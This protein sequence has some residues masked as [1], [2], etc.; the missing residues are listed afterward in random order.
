MLTAGKDGTDWIVRIWN[1]ASGTELV[2]L[3]GHSSFVSRAT[4]SQDE[5]RGVLT[6]SCD[7]TARLWDAASEQELVRLK[8]H[9]D[10]VQER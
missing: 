3:E 1:A 5:R 7:G 9:T 6:A 8:G 2:R 10:Y 4:W